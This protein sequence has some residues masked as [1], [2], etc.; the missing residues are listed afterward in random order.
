MMINENSKEDLDELLGS[1]ESSAM[2]GSSVE[3]I[4]GPPSWCSGWSALLWTPHS[5]PTF[6]LPQSFNGPCLDSGLLLLSQ[7]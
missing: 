1:D 3:M 6:D 7:D 4:V 5:N 2:V